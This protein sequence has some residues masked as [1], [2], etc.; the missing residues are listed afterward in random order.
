MLV[1]YQLFDIKSR[2]DMP[3]IVDHDERRNEL[4]AAVWRVASREGLEAI[5]VRRVAE[6]AGWSTGALVHY[7]SDKEELI[8]FAFELTADRVARRIEAATAGRTDPLQVARTMLVEALPL[9]RERR[10]E[11]RLWF[12]FLGLALTRPALARA[13]RDAYRAW[14]GMLAE[15]L[16]RAQERGDL[17]PEL[18]R[19]REAA[20]LIALADGLAVQA[21]FEPRALSPEL[22]LELVDERLARLR[23]ESPAPAR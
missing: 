23:A 20:A 17:A 19:E 15:A 3:K 9:D 12:A 14:R 11:V 4:A 22:Q 5:T 7:F 8:R 6:E 21:T 16:G 18:D 13:Q 10:T 2:I 1:L